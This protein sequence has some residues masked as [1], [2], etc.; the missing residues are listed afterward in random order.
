MAY[1]GAILN[2]GNLGGDYFLNFFLINFAG[3]PAKFFSIPLMERIGRRRLYMLF[4]VMAGIVCMFTIYPVLKKDQC[5]LNVCERTAHVMFV[6]D[7][8]H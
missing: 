5:K 3:L 8:P 7:M 2:V 1:Y 4:M 6:H